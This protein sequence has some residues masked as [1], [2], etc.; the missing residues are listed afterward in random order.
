M[1]KKRAKPKKASVNIDISTTAEE[2]NAE[3]VPD[4]AKESGVKE[5]FA[6][7]EESS[8]FDF[9]KIGHRRRVTEG[10]SDL[11]KLGERLSL[12][13]SARAACEPELIEFTVHVIKSINWYEDEI[14]REIEQRTKWFWFTIGLTIVFNL[15]VLALDLLGQTESLTGIVVAM[16]LS[17]AA[18]VHRMIGQYLEHRSVHIVL[19]DTMSN[20]KSIWYHIEDQWAD[21]LDEGDFVKVAQFLADLRRSVKEAR[22]LMADEHIKL[23]SARSAPIVD[24]EYTPPVTNSLPDELKD[25]SGVPLQGFTFDYT[26]TE[27]EKKRV[28]TDHQKA[29]LS[30]SNCDSL[31]A[32]ERLKLFATYARP[33]SHLKIYGTEDFGVAT[34]GGDSIALNMDVLL[35][36][37]NNE[38]PQ[39]L[40]HEM[41]HCAGYEHEEKK[42]GDKPGDKSDYYTSPPLRAEKCIA[43][44]Q[45]DVIESSK[46]SR[47]PQSVKSCTN[48]NGKFSIKDQNDTP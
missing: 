19:A 18:A 20:V 41:M 32:D 42:D 21:K 22:R 27:D 3:D 2:S 33:I 45:S 11:K 4:I 7:Q 12:T 26:Y 40:I 17:T 46:K 28:L 5:I 38:L 36:L 25:E 37:P 14:G 16:F 48:L 44:I 9:E 47:S 13:K 34:K 24:I 43:G 39:T 30:I 31:D 10:D 23:M 8:A 15:I 35:G 1:G 29:L 6:D